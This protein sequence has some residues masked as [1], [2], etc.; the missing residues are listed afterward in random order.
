MD[1]DYLIIMAGSAESER[2]FNP[3]SA[4]VN[5]I[6]NLS[7]LPLVLNPRIGGIF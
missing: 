3:L 7:N 4:I 6:H 1:E 5:L 2:D